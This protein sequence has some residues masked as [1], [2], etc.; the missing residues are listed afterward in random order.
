ML[1]WFDQRGKLR[2]KATR[3]E[4]EHYTLLFDI[5]FSYGFKVVR[6]WVKDGSMDE[7]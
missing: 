1:S 7:G 5:S 4:E 3:S 6:S 2:V